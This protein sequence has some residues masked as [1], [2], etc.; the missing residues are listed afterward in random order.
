[1]R[2]AEFSIKYRTFVLFATAV[3]CLGGIQSYF[4]LGKLED[5]EFSIKSALVI[6]KYPGASPKEVEEEVTEVIE[7]AAQQLPVLDKIK[8][9]SKAGLSIVQVDIKENFRAQHLPQIWG[10]IEAKN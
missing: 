1:M 5:P 3:F 10:R 4:R 6:T 2:L 8:S 9:I 7:K